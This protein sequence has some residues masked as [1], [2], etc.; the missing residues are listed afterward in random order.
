MSIRLSQ[1]DRL[2]MTGQNKLKI[3]LFG[4]WP[5]VAVAQKQESRGARGATAGG[6]VVVV[7]SRYPPA[8]PMSVLQTHVSAAEFA[9]RRSTT[10]WLAALAP[11]LPF[12]PPRPVI[13]GR[14]P[15]SPRPPELHRRPDPES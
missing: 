10:A 9:D 8:K 3:G 14:H 4:A 7:M 5:V 6:T 12:A 2:A 1:A 11:D 15:R 13:I